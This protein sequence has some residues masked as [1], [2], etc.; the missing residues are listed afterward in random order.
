MVQID[1]LNETLLHGVNDFNKRAWC[2]PDSPEF[3]NWFFRDSPNTTVLVAHEQGRW[4]SVLGVFDRTYLIGGEPVICGETYAWQTAD[5]CRGRGIGI[6][7]IKAMIDLGRPLV[8][9]GGSPDTLSF[10]PRLGF[11]TVAQAPAL[12]LLLSPRAIGAQAGVAGLSGPKAVLARLGLTLLAPV[13]RPTAPAWSAIRNVPLP[14]LDQETLDMP[15]LPGFQAL[16]EQAFFEWLMMVPARP[17]SFLPFRFQRDGE[18]VGWAFARVAEEGPGELVGRILE[19][20]FAP[21]TTAADQKAMAAAVV[22]ALAGFGVII[23]RALATCAATNGAL[24]ALR[25][26]ARTKLPAMVQPAGR[27]LASEPIRCSML[28]ADGAL[29]PL[30]AR[31]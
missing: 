29:L 4:L 5:E 9:L 28:R 31:A 25:F 24:R 13:M 14:V 16:Y 23:V 1:R 12:N 2:F 21:Q 15:S 8:A 6:K 30:S 17:G 22:Q 18:L 26:I 11:E 7:V 3:L 10:M 20:K 27:T 19:L